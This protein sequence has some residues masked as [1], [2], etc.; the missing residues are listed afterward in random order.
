MSEPQWANLAFS[1]HCHVCLCT[2]RGAPDWNLRVRLCK[3][4]AKEH[5]VESWKAPLVDYTGESSQSWGHLVP[6]RHDNK[7]KRDVIFVPELLAVKK[8]YM[9]LPDD[10][11]REA[12]S[13]ERREVVKSASVHAR[14][15]EAWFNRKSQDRSLELEEI[16]RARRHAIIERLTALGWGDELVPFGTRDSLENHKLVKDPKP[17]TDRIWANIRQP[18][19]DFMEDMKRQ[20]LA[21][22]RKRLIIFRKRFAVDALRTFKR[23]Q[24]PLTAIMPEPVDFCAFPE[25]K[26]VLESPTE[27]DLSEAS[28]ADVVPLLPDIFRR[29]REEVHQKLVR[30]LQSLGDYDDDSDEDPFFFRRRPPPKDGFRGQPEEVIESKLNLA[31]TIFKC[32]RC[33]SSQG[34]N[35]FGVD[36]D[37]DDDEDDDPYLSM[38]MMT[39]DHH[40]RD[41]SKPL[42]YPRALAHQCLT[43]ATDWLGLS[44]A[45]YTMRLSNGTD[46]RK[47]WSAN[48]LKINVRAGKNAATVVQ[49]C[50]LDPESATVDEMDQLDARLACVACTRQ[51]PADGSTLTQVFGWRSAIQHQ[52]AAHNTRNDPRWMR[53]SGDDLARALDAEEEIREDYSKLGSVH[54][55][56]NTPSDLVVWCC[57]HCQDLPSEVDLMTLND[58]KDH[59]LSEHDVLAPELNKDYHE[60]F[61][62]PQSYR[63][64]TYPQTSEVDL[65]VPIA[66]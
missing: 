65:K 41:T 13:A 42:F 53:I 43:R 45:D 47:A 2:T 22:E 25:I 44:S 5:V 61:E 1:L 11:A 49:A 15:C 16:K 58:V 10:R 34:Y 17:L 66:R 31:T 35:F 30:R 52:G 33:A 40:P 3:N 18:L 19:I 56:S 55:K 62:G 39:H 14:L 63:T 26:A 8:K 24:L 32:S 48:V 27:V 28:F 51:G 38:F 57:T 9:S 59:L 36:S 50:G 64:W 46:S 12:Y 21:L 7:R 54:S 23:S 60:S 4:C 6:R 29:W 37:D 20:R